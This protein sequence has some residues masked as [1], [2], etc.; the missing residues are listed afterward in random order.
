MTTKKPPE[1]L[2]GNK[3]KDKNLR[4]SNKNKI[5]LN[6]RICLRKENKTSK[7]RKAHIL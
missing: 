3:R 7:R 5:S 2:K 4:K 1:F 6:T